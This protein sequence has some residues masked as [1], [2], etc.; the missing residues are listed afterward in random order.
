M[1]TRVYDI[2]GTEKDLAWLAE[3]WDGCEVLP[4]R[5]LPGDTEYWQLVAIYCTT[6]PA[7]LKAEVGRNA[8]T[9]AGNQ[10]VVLTWP[11]LTNPSGDLETLPTSQ[12]NWAQRGVTQRTEGSG[13]TGF[14]LGSTFG[15]FYHAWVQSGAPSDCLSKTGMKGG[16]NHNGPLHGVWML[17]E[18]APVY[19]T[20]YEALKGEAQR[21]Q[22]VRF[23]P[24]AALQSRI[25]ADGFVPNSNEFDVMFDG[26]TYRAQ[27]A[28]HLATG[29]CRA[30][31]CELDRW[32]TVYFAAWTAEQ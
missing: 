13:I 9:P 25:F 19:L 28:E 16:T 8:T 32:D 11:N 14:G 10:P 20:L 12:H 7:V 24:S 27:R 3:A 31:Y 30:Y 5:I 18:V 22:L 15:P 4:A 29:V 26:V 1:T 6:G 23:N 21:N 2:D 17:T